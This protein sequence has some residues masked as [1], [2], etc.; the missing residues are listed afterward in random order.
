MQQASELQIKNEPM[1]FSASYHFAYDHATDITRSFLEKVNTYMG[2]EKNE[3]IVDSRVH[4]LMPGW[5]PCIPGWHLDDVPRSRADG[6]PDHVNPIYKSEH[7]MAII[8]D[9]SQT[10][11]LDARLRLEDVPVN[12][13]GSIY[14]R[15]NSDIKS[16]IDAF[17]LR[18]IRA[19]S[20][21]MVAFDWQTF[22]RG[23][24]ATKNGW[25]WFIR[26]SRNTLRQRF[27]EVRNQ[28]QAYLPALEEGW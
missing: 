24:P 25:R 14:G 18:T 7:V 23:M 13:G 11:F 20:S 19:Q 28:V 6:Q 17:E 26:A 16:L 12:S 8:G 4:M 21:E 15:W 9:A 2:W 5:Y 10:Q 22:H 3:I 27:N 1:L